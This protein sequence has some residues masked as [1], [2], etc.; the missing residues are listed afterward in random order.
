MDLALTKQ[1]TFRLPQTLVDRV[2]DCV[3]SIQEKSGMNVTRADVV[4]LLLTRALD[5]AGC[6]LQQLFA[7]PPKA[8]R[9]RAR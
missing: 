9:R 1:L 5:S 6:D 8:R 3:T 4:R 7:A 2:E